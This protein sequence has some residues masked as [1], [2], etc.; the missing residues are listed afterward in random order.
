MPAPGEL[1]ERQCRSRDEGCDGQSRRLGF[2]FG[3][4]LGLGSGLALGLWLL[5]GPVTDSL[6]EAY[7][8]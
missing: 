4:G 5:L 7:I 2:G 3:L 1:S 8:T 6:G